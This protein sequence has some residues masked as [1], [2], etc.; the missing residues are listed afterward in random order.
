M[1]PILHFSA[2][3]AEPARLPSRIANSEN[4]A[5]LAQSD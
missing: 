5:A 1:I 2:K 4:A 3:A